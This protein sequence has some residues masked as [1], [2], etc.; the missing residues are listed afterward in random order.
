MEDRI[1]GADYRMMRAGKAEDAVRAAGIGLASRKLRRARRIVQTE[2]EGG[3]VLAGI[4]RQGETAN[5][6]QQALGSDRIGD[7]DAQERPPQTRAYAVKSVHRQPI[8]GAIMKSG[9]SRVKCAK[10]DNRSASA[11]SAITSAA[12]A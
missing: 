8:P 12:C 4:C 1:R 7:D 5:R 6:N 3:C 9:G 10:C 2:F 11:A